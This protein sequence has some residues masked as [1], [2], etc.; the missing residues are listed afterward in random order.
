MMGF[1]QH[2]QARVM[3]G[4]KI[5]A[6]AA[7][8]YRAEWRPTTAGQYQKPFDGPWGF[9]VTSTLSP[10]IIAQQLEMTADRAFGAKQGQW[11]VVGAS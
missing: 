10:D 2:S 4:G 1:S 8:K 3:T 6:R 5:P 11:T 9:D 7:R